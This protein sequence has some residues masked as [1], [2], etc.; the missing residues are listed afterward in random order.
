MAKAKK[1][2]DSHDSKHFQVKITYQNKVEAILLSNNHTR[3][4]KVLKLYNCFEYQKLR[5]SRL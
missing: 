5:I 3:K 2:K 4:I 1:T